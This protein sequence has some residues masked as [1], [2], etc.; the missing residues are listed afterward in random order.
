LD[1]AA[2]LQEFVNYLTFERK[3]AQNTRVSYELDLTQFLNWLAE[4]KITTVV[5]RAILERYL[6]YLRHDLG[7]K[8]RSQARKVS[9][10]RQ[11]FKY[12]ERQE[13]LVPSP[14][15]LLDAPAQAKHLP[16]TL[17]EAQVNALLRAPDDATA[18]GLRDR[19][20]LELLYATGLRVS[21]L[22]GLQLQQFRMERRFLQVIGKGNKERLVPFGKDAETW[23]KRYI[24]QGR[25][26]LLKHRTNDLFL[27]RFGRAMT[28]QAFWQHIKRY[29]LEVGIP[30]KMISPHVLRHSFATHLLDHGAD[31]R[32][33]QM[34]LGHTDLS[35]TEIY[36][37][38]AKERLRQVH[39]R[40]HPLEKLS[41]D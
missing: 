21:E 3:L 40:F 32:A 13:I 38:V 1:L 20:M 6:A 23:L 33:I 30:A 11:F 39:E 16:K 10:L 7:V 31:L 37:A 12:L 14:M 25:P 29:G 27:N 28:R 2:Y 34:M 9:A 26:A 18:F 36:T 15:S 5:D 22:I 17:N 8:D 41:H 35:T 24:D 4:E 19:A